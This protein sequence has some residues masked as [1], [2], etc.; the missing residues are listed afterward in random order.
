[1]FH[2]IFYVKPLKIYIFFNDFNAQ[3]GIFYVFLMERLYR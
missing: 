3:T 1:M 2:V